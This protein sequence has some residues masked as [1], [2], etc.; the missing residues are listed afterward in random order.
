MQWEQYHITKQYHMSPFRAIKSIHVHTT[1]HTRGQPEVTVWC[2][3]VTFSLFFMLFS[4]PFPTS[5]HSAYV[6]GKLL[7]KWLLTAHSI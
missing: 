6:I 5:L 4:L 2:G 3:P 1:E 7:S